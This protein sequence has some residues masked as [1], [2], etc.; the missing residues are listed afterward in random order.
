MIFVHSA[1]GAMHYVRIGY[2]NALHHLG[3]HVAYI[4]VD[5][6]Y[7]KHLEQYRPSMIIGSTWDIK[8]ENVDLLNKIVPKLVLR[9]SE[10]SSYAD[11]IGEPLCIA[12]EEEKSIISQLKNVHLHTYYPAEW[13]EKLTSGWGKVQ[14]SLLACDI[15]AYYQVKAES[16]N[17]TFIGGW[18]PYKAKYLQWIANLTEGWV[19]GNGK[20]PTPFYR[21][22]INDND[23]K[24]AF[25]GALICPN[26]MEP[27]AIDY[28]FDVNERSY[29]TMGCGSLSLIQENDAAKSIFGNNIDYF[30]TEEELR[31]KMDYYLSNEKARQK[32]ADKG[33]DFI[34]S[35]HTYTHRVKE[36][37]TQ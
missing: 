33:R 6:N 14:S 22:P 5:E 16:S 9:C 23:V 25:S 1:P 19:Y 28:G 12:T 31:S 24:K 7:N 26:V 36:W 35:K 30:S 34:L 21:G 27:F 32:M 15:H 37:L 8:Q 2:V 20:W 4:Q 17:W 11:S 29:K 18:W 13:V 10:W 3:E